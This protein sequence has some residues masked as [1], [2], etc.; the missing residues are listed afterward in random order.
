MYIRV[1][2]ARVGSATAR[3]DLVAAKVVPRVAEVGP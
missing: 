1:V 3:V 2:A